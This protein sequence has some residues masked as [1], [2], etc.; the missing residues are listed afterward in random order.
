MPT[1]K[2]FS[3]ARTASGSSASGVYS[4]SGVP[5][6]SHHCGRNGAYDHEG[7]IPSAEGRVQ[8][9]VVSGQ[10]TAQQAAPLADGDAGP[11]SGATLV[12]S[13]IPAASFDPAWEAGDYV[14]TTTNTGADHSGAGLLVKVTVAA[15]GNMT[16]DSVVEGGEGYT[17]ASDDT[18]ILDLGLADPTDGAITIQA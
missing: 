18:A 14:V 12:T 13:P 6:V 2:A 10:T 11:A 7:E 4:Y 8:T 5:G 15:N 9:L 16:I 1:I 3:V 17:T